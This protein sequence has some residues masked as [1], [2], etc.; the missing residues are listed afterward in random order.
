MQAQSAQK[1]QFKKEDSLIYFFQKGR[2]TDSITTKNG[3]LFFLHVPY[4]LKPYVSILIQNGRFVNT[5]N[6]SLVQFEYLAGMNY[7]YMYELIRDEDSKNAKTLFFGNSFVNGSNRAQAHQ[8]E[9]IV[10][11]K[12][13]DKVL[14][15]NQ[16]YFKN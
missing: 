6:D 4:Q 2:P 14:I 12:R 10:R 3:N 7:E 13:E 15:K 9:I 1:I 11:D 16:F 8:I 5:S